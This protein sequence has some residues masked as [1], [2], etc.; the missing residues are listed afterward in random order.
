MLSRFIFSLTSVL[1]LH[2][3]KFCMPLFYIV[4]S[5]VLTSHCV[6]QY[7]LDLNLWL[8]SFTYLISSAHLDYF[9]PASHSCVF[10]PSV[11]VVFNIVSSVSFRYFSVFFYLRIQGLARRVFSSSPLLPCLIFEFISCLVTFYVFSP[12]PIATQLSSFHVCS[13]CS[14]PFC[15]LLSC[16]I[17]LFPFIGVCCIVISFLILSCAFCLFSRVLSL[18]LLRSVFYLSEFALLL[19]IYSVLKPCVL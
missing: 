2:H 9:Y 6:S 4:L 1:L 16:L 10:S 5:S 17:L 11:P 19:V 15:L 8:P 13:A 7:D 14:F 12:F 3:V 18:A